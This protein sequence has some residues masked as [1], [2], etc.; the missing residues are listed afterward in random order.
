[1]KSGRLV[2]SITRTKKVRSAEEADLEWA[3]ATKAEHVPDTGPTAPVVAAPVNN[4]LAIARARREAAQASMREMELAKRL[5][6]LVP[7]KEVETK[8]AELFAH[9]RTRLMDIPRKARQHDASLSAA[10]LVLLEGLIRQALEDL[11]D[12]EEEEESDG[13]AAAE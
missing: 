6:E 9:C 1:M 12:P 13:P 11:A 8:L 7:A 2:A 4:E 3:A 10:H 5:G